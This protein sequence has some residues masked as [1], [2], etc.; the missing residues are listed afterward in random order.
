MTSEFLQISDDERRKQAERLQPV[1]LRFRTSA[2]RSSRATAKA[3]MENLTPRIGRNLFSLRGQWINALLPLLVVTAIGQGAHGDL[4]E[5]RQGSGLDFVQKRWKRASD[6]APTS[7]A[8]SSSSTSLLGGTRARDGS[9]KTRSQNL[10]QALKRQE[11]VVVKN[12]KVSSN[13]LFWWCEQRN[14]ILLECMRL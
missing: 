13:C 12:Q 14:V 1:I 11:P 5:T 4:L 9:V 6:E 3:R 10:P 2:K 7:P 8:L